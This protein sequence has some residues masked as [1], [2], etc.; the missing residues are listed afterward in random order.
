M[1]TEVETTS[2]YGNA[3]FPQPLHS[4]ILKYNF[5]SLSKFLSQRQWVTKQSSPKDLPAN[6]LRCY[7]QSRLRSGMIAIQVFSTTTEPLT[8]ETAAIAR[9]KSVHWRLS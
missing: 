9:Y 4:W 7:L 6:H 8:D 5:T 1:G 3:V 2:G